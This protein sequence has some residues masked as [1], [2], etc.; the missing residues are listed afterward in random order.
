M[1]TKATLYLDSVMY[2]TLKMRAA[3]TG[4]SIS[5]LMNE[6]LQAQLSEDLEDIKTIRSRLAKKERPLSYEAALKE[7]QQNG[8]I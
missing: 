7:L 3:E 5:S 2:K 1:T 8:T 6:A 4:E